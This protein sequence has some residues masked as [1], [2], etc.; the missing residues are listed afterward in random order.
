[1]TRPA[2]WK[3]WVAALG[4]CG[5]ERGDK[6]N[7]YIYLDIYRLTAWN[8]SKRVKGIYKKGF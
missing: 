4:W 3:K 1:V 7:K 6:N 8:L 5:N 2:H